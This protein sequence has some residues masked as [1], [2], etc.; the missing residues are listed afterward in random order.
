MSCN[1]SIDY[2]TYLFHKEKIIN[3][4]YEE[5]SQ[6]VFREKFN[7]MLQKIKNIESRQWIKQKLFEILGTKSYVYDKMSIIEALNSIEKNCYGKV[8]KDDIL[9]QEDDAV[10]TDIEEEDEDE[11]EEYNEEEEVEGFENGIFDKLVEGFRS[12]KKRKK[13]KKKKK[14]K[15]KEKTRYAA[16]V[17]WKEQCYEHHD[18]GKKKIIN[19]TLTSENNDI[20]DKTCS[21]IE[22]ELSDFDTY[23]EKLCNH[24]E[25]KSG[26]FLSGNEY[27]DESRNISGTGDD[28]YIC[29]KCNLPNDYLMKP[30]ANISIYDAILEVLLH[31]FAFF[32][33]LLYTII[34]ANLSF[35]SN[36]DPPTNSKTEIKSMN[37]VFRMIEFII[38]ATVKRIT[39]NKHENLT[40]SQGKTVL[41]MIP[42]F[43][44]ISFSFIFGFY[45]GGLS[46]MTAH[47]S[48]F[49]SVCFL[50]LFTVFIITL[51]STFI[52]GP[53]IIPLLNSLRSWNWFFLTIIILFGL[54]VLFEAISQIPN[55]S[56]NGIEGLSLTINKFFNSFIS[57]ILKPLHTLAKTFAKKDMSYTSFITGF[58]E[59]VILSITVYIPVM[60]FYAIMFAVVSRYSIE[61]TKKSIMDLFKNKQIS[62]YVIILVLCLA[63]IYGTSWYFI[64]IDKLYKPGMSKFTLSA[65]QGA[66]TLIG[67]LTFLLYYLYKYVYAN[68]ES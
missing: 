3:F 54:Y 5:N 21:Q 67:P 18:G 44:I 10:E 33:I 49:G 42:I 38:S 59:V 47:L 51:H 30:I 17:E 2:K 1:S 46:H 52:N 60:F 29:N 22:G 48:A 40:T 68:N 63:V 50:I 4:V 53:K 31:V 37:S 56:F 27:I 14:K 9:L 25:L 41:F 64:S 36:V 16:Y 34:F 7:Q 32:T 39:S 62:A 15:R 35:E 6:V 26:Y 12:K 61:D 19:T 58:F 28:M 55:I 23:K 11:D 66:F 24:C 65:L 45:N 43:I 13:K 20:N 57:A 8:A